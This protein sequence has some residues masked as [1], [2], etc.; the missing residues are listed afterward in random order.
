MGA[1]SRPGN[2]SI[3]LS[4]VVK[5]R[6]HEN[7]DDPDALFALAALRVEQGRLDEAL[8]VIDRLLR[9][10]PRYPGVWRLKATVHRLKGEKRAARTAEEIE[11]AAVE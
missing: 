8:F 1:V 9:I 4:V 5:E 11:Q 7:S 10:D 3:G 6:L 2:R